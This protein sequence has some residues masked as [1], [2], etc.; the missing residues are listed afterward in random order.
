M[1]YKNVEK[2]RFAKGVTKTFI[3][4]KAKISLQVYHNISKG[5]TSLDAERLKK[6]AAALDV[7]PSIFFDDKLTDNVIKRLE[8]K[9]DQ[10][11]I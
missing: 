11:A 4:K 10:E 6:I 8:E 7:D 2:V 1:I 5:L 3:A 9:Q